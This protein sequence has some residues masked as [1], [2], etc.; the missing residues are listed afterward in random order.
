M[1]TD[2]EVTRHTA[3]KLGQASRLIEGAVDDL[4][5]RLGI[6]E[7]VEE[8]S[9]EPQSVSEAAAVV[10]DQ[11]DA[12]MSHIFEPMLVCLRDRGADGAQTMLGI[13]QQL[14]QMDGEHWAAGEVLQRLVNHLYGPA[15]RSATEKAEQLAT[16]YGGKTD[17]ADQYGP[18]PFRILTSAYVGFQF[19]DASGRD[20]SDISSERFRCYEFG[21]DG[22]ETVEVII[23]EPQFISVSEKGHRVVDRFG[24]CHYVPDGWNRLVWQVRD[25]APHFTF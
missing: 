7:L 21:D 5:A 19:R 3:R 4:L 18:V 8:E 15:E 11:L 6:D 1:A 16:A 2:I 20:W 10:L 22:E 25:G 12:E 13:A 14:M 17:G 24:F 23:A 9:S